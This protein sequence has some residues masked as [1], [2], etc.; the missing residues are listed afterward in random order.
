MKQGHDTPEVAQEK[1][2]RLLG[3][4]EKA[5]Q[6]TVSDAPPPKVVP[7]FL[8]GRIPAKWKGNGK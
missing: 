4:T 6:E 3:Q 7:K 5:A 2:R 1:Q 8:T